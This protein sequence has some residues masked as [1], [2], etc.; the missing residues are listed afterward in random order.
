MKAFLHMTCH[1]FPA[2][3]LYLS[4]VE[5]L[6]TVGPDRQKPRLGRDRWHVI[7]TLGVNLLSHE[8]NGQTGHRMLI[9]DEIVS[10]AVMTQQ[11]INS[12]SR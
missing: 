5:C 9:N 7:L 6:E 2:R 12:E 11:N 1:L 8:G 4:G 10:L 3:G